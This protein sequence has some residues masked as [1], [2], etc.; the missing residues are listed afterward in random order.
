M[1]GELTLANGFKLAVLKQNNGQHNNHNNGQNKRHRKILCVHGWLDNAASFLPLIPLITDAEIVAIDLPGHG[2]SDHEDSIYP[3]TSQAHTLL[4]AADALGWD[5]FTLI[6]HSL[7]GCIAPFT[8]VA[9]KNRIENLILIEAAGPRAERPDELPTRLEKFHTDMREPNK[10]QSRLFDT[11]DQA[12][13]SRLH[14]NKMNVESAKLIVERQLKEAVHEDK[15]GLQWRFDSKLRITS[16]SY[17]TEQQIQAVLNNISCPVLCV[18]AES[19]YLTDRTET[20]ERLQCIPDCKSVTLP[21][22]HHLHLDTPE[23]VA[24]EINSFLN[25]ENP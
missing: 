20:V 24:Q 25:R 22:H 11:I 9:A 10:Y 8:A 3:I 12:I 18:I 7:G 6:G 4:A 13:A 17:F 14:A 16:P 5:N 1:S 19:G 2:H 23:P 21:G 15:K